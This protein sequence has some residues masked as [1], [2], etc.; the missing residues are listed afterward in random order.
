MIIFKG[1]IKMKLSPEMQ[2][3]IENMISYYDYHH[4]EIMINKRPEFVIDDF[5]ELL[6]ILADALEV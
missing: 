4:I 6:K 3:L 5:K 2:E 1:G